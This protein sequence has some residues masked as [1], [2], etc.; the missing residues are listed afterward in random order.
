[1]TPLRVLIAEAIVVG[2]V[3]MVVG[4]LVG[5]TV[6]DYHKASTGKA[7]GVQPMLASLFLTGALVHV[8]FEVVGLNEYYIT[9]K[10]K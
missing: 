10:R 2:L 4:T 3:T 9:Y 6:S 5:Y 7:W 1:M 8:G